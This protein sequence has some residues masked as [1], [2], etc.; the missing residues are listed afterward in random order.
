MEFAPLN[1]PRIQLPSIQLSLCSFLIL[2]NVPR[3]P[4]VCEPVLPGVWEPAVWWHVLRRGSNGVLRSVFFI[5][6]GCEDV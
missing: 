5:V 6:L 2:A 3:E 4:H 1:V